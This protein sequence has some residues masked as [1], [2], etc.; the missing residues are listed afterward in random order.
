MVFNGQ[1]DSKEDFAQDFAFPRPRVQCGD[2][3]GLMELRLL[4][5]VVAA[6]ELSLSW[7]LAA[8]VR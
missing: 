8:A 5:G 7:T 6:T 3:D 4:A 2:A 1:T